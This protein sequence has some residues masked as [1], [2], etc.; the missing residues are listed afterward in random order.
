MPADDPNPLTPRPGWRASINTLTNRFN[1]HLRH[2]NDLHVK[3]AAAMNDVEDRLRGVE[4]R[5]F[6]ADAARRRAEVA[7]RGPDP[8]RE[9]ALLR[10]RQLTEERRR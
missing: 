6:S 7:A 5:L 8:E 4:A 9:R 1:E 10:Q 3:F 2:E